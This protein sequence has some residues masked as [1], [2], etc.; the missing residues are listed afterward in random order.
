M[1]IIHWSVRSSS[2]KGGDEV[3]GENGAY[4]TGAPTLLENTKIWCNIKVII[5]PL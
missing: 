2:R 4:F 1:E 3:K 5:N